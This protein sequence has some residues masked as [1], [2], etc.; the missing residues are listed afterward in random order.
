M[1]LL[2]IGEKGEKEDHLLVSAAQKEIE[3]HTS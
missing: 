3:T 2:S 1:F